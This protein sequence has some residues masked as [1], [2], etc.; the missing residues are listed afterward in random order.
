MLAL[1]FQ[2]ATRTVF[3][4]ILVVSALLVLLLPLVEVTL[5]TPLVS[6][7][8]ILTATFITT[9]AHL[10]NSVKKGL[11]RIRTGFVSI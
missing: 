9:L 4:S 7:Q 2:I 8:Q 1:L 5:T 11:L 6:L 10:V 3:G